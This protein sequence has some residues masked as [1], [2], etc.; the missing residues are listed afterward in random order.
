MQAGPTDQRQPKRHDGNL[1]MT[2]NRVRNRMS[3]ALGKIRRRLT[4]DAT[5][6]IHYGIGTFTIT[7]PPG[8]MLPEYKR[9]HPNYDRFLPHL[10]QHLNDAE[11]VVDI[12]ANVGD[13]LAAMFHA[14]KNLRYICIEPD[15]VFFWHLSENIERI[16]SAG[17]RVAVRTIKALVGT[18]LP[19]VTLK[20]KDGTKKAVMSADG[21][22]QCERLDSL[23]D[24]AE[25]TSV[26]L[27]KSDV[28]GFDWDVLSSS[29]RVIRSS[30]PL[31]FFELYHDDESQY[32]GYLDL[33][34]V[35]EMDGYTGWVMFDNFGNLMLK[36][37][38]TDTVRQLMSY[39]AAQNAGRS[40]RTIFYLDVLAVHGN[41]AAFVES[42]LRTY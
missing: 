29:S 14:N 1:K 27:L 33:I 28:D 42:V 4:T 37:G 41:D 39:V 15:D 38:N 26:R 11:L 32:R 7:L 12:G 5:A 3:R 36:T 10:V 2:L 23:I 30:K 22:F 13:T 18:S 20:G 19:A 8:H 31:I 35:L 17:Q 34:N 25:I 21:K 9:H 16:N 24:E 6:P 40:T